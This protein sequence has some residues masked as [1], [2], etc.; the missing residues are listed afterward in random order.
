MARRA[1]RQSKQPSQDPNV[2]AFDAVN[3]LTGRTADDLRSEAARMLG[4]L[5]GSKGGHERAKRLTKKR[6]AEIARQG[7]KARWKDHKKGQG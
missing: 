6:R 7:A 3:A 2:A 4:L 5:G 1:S